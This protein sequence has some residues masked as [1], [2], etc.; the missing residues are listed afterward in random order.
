MIW[1]AVFAPAGGDVVKAGY[2]DKT[3]PRKGYGV[4]VV[5]DV[6]IPKPNP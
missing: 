2:Q 6:V 4:R 5:I 1:S 3:K